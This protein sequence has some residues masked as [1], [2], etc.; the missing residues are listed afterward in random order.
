MKLPL[1]AGWRRKKLPRSSQRLRS[2][3]RPQSYAPAWV[4]GRKLVQA[5]ALAAFLLLFLAARWPDP[6]WKAWSGLFFKLDPLAALANWLHSLSSGQ[7]AAAGKLL[8]L[9]LF[10][11]G[12]TLLA[13]RAWCGWLCPLGTLLD[14]IKPKREKHNVPV[15]T[16]PS[17][18]L[19]VV[20]YILLFLT[21][22]TALFGGL[23]WMALDPLTLLERTLTHAIWPALN[24][25]VTQAEY[26]LYR[27]LPASGEAL[28]RF[29]DWVRPGLLPDM[30]ISRAAPLLFGALFALVVGLNW[31]VPRFWCR[32][33][34]PLGGLLGLLSKVAVVRRT[35]KTLRVS[36]LP[37]EGQTLRVLNDEHKECT[38]CKLCSR[39]CPTGTI[40][41]QRNFASDPAECTLCLECLD[42]CPRQAADF[43]PV[44]SIAPRLPYDPGRREALFSL[45][46]AALSV[47]LLGSSWLRSIQHPG[48]IRPPGVVEDLLED[49]GDM[50]GCIRCGACLQACPT[51][52]LQPALSQAGLEGLWTPVLVPRLGY[53]DYSCNACGQVCPV[54]AIAA[55]TLNEKRTQVLGKAYVDKDRC[56][57]WADGTPCIVCEEMCPLPEKAITWDEGIS[58][59]GTEPVQRPVVDRE[60]CIGC[61]ICEYK[62]PVVGEAAIRVE[63]A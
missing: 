29:D 57:A 25:L 35:V 36:S 31:I 44:I 63:A 54:G 62:C 17:E 22:F 23:F 48:R 39:R 11:V 21:L 34:C 55:L 33:L 5:L 30:P 14:W 41:P 24:W 61:G 6:A 60:K 10:T 28:A 47:A 56:L 59:P 20:K 51:S 9:S 27:L 42:A 40:D 3:H 38:A 7:W 26:G 16:L 46:G 52:A 49:G 12:L 50:P 43:L 45:G 4:A 32:Y 18:R 15:Q 1:A 58:V 19:R 2:S 13:G 8:W 53:C 37:A